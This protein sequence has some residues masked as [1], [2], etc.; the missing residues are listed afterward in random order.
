M[1]VFILVIAEIKKTL[2]YKDYY[3]TIIAVYESDETTKVE[4]IFQKISL[5]IENAKTT[6]H[7][8]KRKG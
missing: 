7:I 4:D 8:E 2:K 6:L 5:K 1:L 3:E